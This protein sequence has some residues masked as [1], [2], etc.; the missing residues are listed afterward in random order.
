[1]V[2]PQMDSNNLRMSITNDNI[3]NNSNTQPYSINIYNNNEMPTPP[4]I[5]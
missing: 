5:F 3:L 4:V 1:M 2:Q